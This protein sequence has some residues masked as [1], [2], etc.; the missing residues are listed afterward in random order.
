VSETRES[1]GGGDMRGDGKEGSG[2][3]TKEDNVEDKEEKD[4]GKNYK[5]AN[6]MS[7]RDGK[8][9][10]KIELVVG[11]ACLFSCDGEQEGDSSRA[12]TNGA[13]GDSGAGGG[14]FGASAGNMNDNGA[15]DASS[16]VVTLLDI[17]LTRAAN[18]ILGE[19]AASFD[20]AHLDSTDASLGRSHTHTHT[21]THTHIH[22]HTHTRTHYHY[23]YHWA[24]T[25]SS[26]CAYG[27][28]HT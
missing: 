13:G 20:D 17:S 15:G 26:P 8:H 27:H 28:T 7:Q 1:S 3:Q 5:N 9:V 12:S 21:H 2:E 16:G 10:L 24:P 25:P 23:Q 19:V 18:L 14:D 22:T 6:D 11:D 4:G